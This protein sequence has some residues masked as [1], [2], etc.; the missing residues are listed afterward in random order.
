MFSQQ[1]RT[2]AFLNWTLVDTG[3]F[4]GQVRSAGGGAGNYTFVEVFEAGHMVPYDQPEA[5]LD[6]IER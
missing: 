1:F 6:M 5:A 2:A 3:V 4:A